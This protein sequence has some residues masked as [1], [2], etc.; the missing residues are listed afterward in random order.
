[1]N[2]QHHIKS[3]WT[4]LVRK[5]VASK[6]RLLRLDRRTACLLCGLGQVTESIYA[7]VGSSVKWR[8]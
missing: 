4:V 2:D 1:M 5:H 8:C 3:N 6:A 7:S